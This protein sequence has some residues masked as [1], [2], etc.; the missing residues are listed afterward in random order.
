MTVPQTMRRDLP[1]LVVA[2]LPSPGPLGPVAQLR[3]LG[4]IPEA[5]TA[6]KLIVNQVETL[7]KPNYSPYS[8]KQNS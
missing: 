4:E 6:L 3:F 2:F 7:G 1:K 5:V 8:P